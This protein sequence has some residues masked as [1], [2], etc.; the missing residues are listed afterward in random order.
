MPVE[1]HNLEI[2]PTTIANS[3]L[4]AIVTNPTSNPQLNLIT[5]QN[6]VANIATAP[7]PPFTYAAYNDSRIVNAA[8]VNNNL[9]DLVNLTTAKS[10]LGLSNV[11][12]IDITTYTGN[13]HTSIIGTLTTGSIPVS[14]ITGLGN[15][16]T[17]NVG[18]TAGT[19]AAGDDS[20][21]NFL[22]IPGRVTFSDADVGTVANT[23]RILAQIGTLTAPRTVTLPLANTVT[24]GLTLTIIDESGTVTASNTITAAI[25]G[26]DRI[27]ASSTSAII[28]VPC[29]SISF[30]SDGTS[31][32]TYKV[33]Q[34]SSPTVQTNLNVESMFN[35]FNPSF[36]GGAK[37][38]GADDTAALS[39]CLNAAA[40]ANSSVYI[41]QTIQIS[42]TILLPT[43]GFKQ[44]NILSVNTSTSTITLSQDPG[45]SN[46]DPI[47]FGGACPTGMGKMTQ[48]YR[49]F[50]N[51]SDRRQVVLYNTRVNAIAGG[52]TGKIII[53]E[54]VRVTGT[55]TGNTLVISAGTEVAT[56]DG[57][58]I[59]MPNGTRVG[60]V[61]AGGGTGTLTMDQS[62]NTGAG[63]YTYACYVDNRSFDGGIKIVGAPGAYLKKHPT[64]TSA[65]ANALIKAAVGSNVEIHGLGFEGLSSQFVPR[66]V[67]ITPTSISNS[68][69]TTTQTVTGPIDWALPGV[70]FSFEGGAYTFYV[71]SVSGSSLTFW[72][73]TTATVWPTAGITFNIG[74]GLSSG[75]V[76]ITATGSNGAT[77]VVVNDTKGLVVNLSIFFAGD[78][79]LN[80]VNGVPISGHKITNINT[81]TKTI[82][83]DNALSVDLSN[84]A[85]TSI[86]G[87]DGLDIESVQNALIEHCFFRHCGDA[88][89]RICSNPGYFQAKTES[90]PNG[91]VSTTQIVLR[92]CDIFN[93]Y[94]TST[95]ASNQYMV[96]G[97]RDVVFE[98]NKF[99][100]LRGSVK[101][102]SRTAGATNIHLI[103][104]LITSSDNHGF[105][106]DT[107][108][109]MFIERNTIMN[110]FNQGIF[111]LPN[112]GG[113][114][115]S[116]TAT[117]T[118]SSTSIVVSSSATLRVGMI[119][120][121]AGVSGQ[122][123]ITNIPDGTHVTVDVACDA[124]VSGAAFSIFGLGIQGSPFNGLYIRNNIFDNCGLATGQLA[125]IRIAP[126]NYSD[127]FKWNYT[128]VHIIGNIFRNVTNTQNIAV[129]II[130]GSFVNFRFEN[131]IIE[132]YQ[133]LNGLKMLLRGVTGVI[134]GF[135]IS[136]NKI[137]MNNTLGSA[138]AIQPTITGQTVPQIN[139][140]DISEN[141][142]TGTCLYGILL[143]NV[144]NTR[145]KKNRMNLTGS[146]GPPAYGAFFFPNN[147]SGFGSI[148][149]LTFDGND[150]ETTNTF[151]YSL[152]GIN[153]LK[154]INNRHKI[155]IGSSTASIANSCTNVTY[156]NNEEIGG[157]PNFNQVPVKTRSS[158]SLLRQEEGAAFPTSGT[159]L[160][161]SKFIQS[162]NNG[163]IEWTCEIPGTF[164][165]PAL[166][167]SPPTAPTAT[168]DGTT[169][170]VTFSS[171]AD[172]PVGCFIN[173]SGAW[174]GAR[175][176]TSVSGNTGIV[177]G[178]T[179]AAV[180]GASITYVAPTFGST[181]IIA[182][183][184]FSDADLVLTSTQRQAE[185]IGTLT[186][187]RTVTL[188]AA[189]SVVKGTTIQVYDI[190]GTVTGSN[191][192]V[193]SR[194]GSDGIVT[195][196]GTVATV[197]MTAPTSLS[198]TSN[199]VNKWAYK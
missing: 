13:T 16:A 134:N 73:M 127:G 39:A 82:T 145:I 45:G 75:I 123:K 139:E 168:T 17:R 101:F 85:C 174:T 42:S 23:T 78:T 170:T 198:F 10:N 169:N 37:G 66:G 177:S 121:I 113:I 142:I 192:I 114:N 80:I 51:T 29:G 130:N 47:Q 165:T 88:A 151:G 92:D 72:R 54:D 49:F 64:W 38:N 34:V 81:S 119:L 122:K 67:T 48:Y 84:A 62:Y 57:T 83:F 52:G 150:F 86:G 116:V 154:I 68:V 102:A 193:V 147:T 180:T 43:T 104:N 140:I 59:I 25:Q 187:S 14:L 133:G 87:D 61:I 176:I 128:D 199:G 15:G 173:V 117:T 182:P 79:N 4:V 195:P 184:T 118:A 58:A 9:S 3:D 99:S 20:R 30:E 131:N 44:P 69:M 126:D 148:D 100:Y 153:S 40:A 35:P 103:G 96:G 164:G 157:T 149:N 27:N 105:E 171:I 166:N 22:N 2:H 156:V 95:T 76:G 185:Q 110:V 7:I 31:K 111:M 77:S 1:N 146:A 132:N 124:P 175:Q 36:A 191:T 141:L 158:S 179:P 159:W 63:T 167:G 181:G 196:S 152:S 55:M 178:S 24:A 97:A 56:E 155:A 194:A 91:G 162:S 189:N 108:S 172:F 65:V 197:T 71:Q 125:G 129:N 50:P 12:N 160:A 109:D 93:C 161:G 115:N 163:P 135:S 136:G 11:Q 60:Y 98:N 188:P 186:A 90:L 138:I 26:S 18:T 120:Q 107:C 143:E 21:F 137:S 183:V 74:Q 8:N 190:S 32:W 5:F 144:T 46:G 19:L 53:T 41:P 94:Q 112:N 33:D 89:I 70:A 28:N 6:F 106:I